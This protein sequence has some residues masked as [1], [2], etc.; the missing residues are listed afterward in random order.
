MT[1]QTRAFK[2]NDLPRR[3]KRRLAAL[4]QG[5]V[6][7]LDA[8][9][10]NRKAV[11]HV[12]DGDRVLH[13]FNVVSCLNKRFR[14]RRYE[15]L[16][17]L[18][19]QSLALAEPFGRYGLPSIKDPSERGAVTGHAADLRGLHDLA[20]LTGAREHMATFTTNP[21]QIHRARVGQNALDRHS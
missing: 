6:K 15:L 20:S 2:R 21:R 8:V 14:I 9:V 18:R 19:K 3:L 16:L 5:L 4:L 1:A 11:T 17:S 13:E 12:V 7:Q 10:Q